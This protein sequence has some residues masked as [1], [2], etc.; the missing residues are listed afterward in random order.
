MLITAGK[1]MGK[2]TVPVYVKIKFNLI[3]LNRSIPYFPAIPLL[4]LCPT[5]ILAHEPKET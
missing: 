3:N 5:E 4:R 2:S 1:V